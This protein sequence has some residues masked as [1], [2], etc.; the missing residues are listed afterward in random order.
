MKNS[1]DHC[2]A[3]LDDGS[4]IEDS[5]GGSKARENPSNHGQKKGKDLLLNTVDEKFNSS[6]QM[7][8][9]DKRET[10]SS[11]DS[12]SK[13]HLHRGKLKLFA[14]RSL[15]LKRGKSLDTHKD[16]MKDFRKEG[17]DIRAL[18]SKSLETKDEVEDYMVVLKEEDYIAHNQESRRPAICEEIERIVETIN[19][20]PLRTQRRNLIVSDNLLK[21]HLL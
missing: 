7:E 5:D 16:E 8:F 13:E 18:N 12:K 20:T 14:L 11:K 6:V 19:G 10:S 4:H 3:L 15:G 1:E 2:D 21:W 9:K 17:R